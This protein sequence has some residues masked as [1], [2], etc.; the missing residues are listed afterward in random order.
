MVSA[1]TKYG[2]RFAVELAIRWGEGPID[3]A[4]AAKK[5]GIPESYLRKIAS[6]LRK[7]GLV[8][9][10]RGQAGGYR[11]NL[12]P[13]SISVLDIYDALETPGSVPAGKPDPVDACWESFERE[14]RERLGGT[15]LEDIARS[16]PEGPSDWNI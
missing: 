7:T 11:L 16:F 12:P 13:S 9:A 4:S 8:A 15:S 6:A 10:D 3:A 2:L 1:G 5:R 14:L